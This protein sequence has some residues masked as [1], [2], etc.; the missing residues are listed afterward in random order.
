MLPSVRRTRGN[1]LRR[2]TCWLWLLQSQKAGCPTGWPVSTSTTVHAWLR[3]AVV[4]LTVGCLLSF[5]D[6]FFYCLFRQFYSAVLHLLP[7][8]PHSL[9]HCPPSVSVLS[10]SLLCSRFYLL[11][12]FICVSVSHSLFLFPFWAARLLTLLF[13][14]LSYLYITLFLSFCFFNL[15]FCS[16]SLCVSPCCPSLV[17]VPLVH[18]LVLSSLSQYISVSKFNIIHLFCLIWLLTTNSSIP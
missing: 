2:K 12:A 15:Y 6:S 7:F 1:D 14:L 13:Y 4:L 18:S 8:A 16:F 9:S 11:L 3:R 5:R 10:S 17:A